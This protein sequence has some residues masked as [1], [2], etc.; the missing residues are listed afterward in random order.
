[1]YLRIFCKL[2]TRLHLRLF[3]LTFLHCLF[4]LC[5]YKLTKFRTKS[6]LLDVQVRR[7]CSGPRSVADTSLFS[8]RK[9][10]LIHCGVRRWKYRHCKE[11]PRQKRLSHRPFNYHTDQ[12]GKHMESV[13]VWVKGGACGFPVKGGID[14]V[15]HA[16]VN[17]NL[18]QRHRVAEVH[19]DR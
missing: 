4:Q 11:I 17:K 8:R 10:V 1:M 7:T 15:S 12:Q 2:Q 18:T 16:R 6:L 9:A 3:M 13:G 19:G 14:L 5:L